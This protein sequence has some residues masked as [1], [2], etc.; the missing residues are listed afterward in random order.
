MAL[1]TCLVAERRVPHRPEGSEDRLSK[2]AP[3]VVPTTTSPVWGA[4]PLEGSPQ[5]EIQVRSQ[6]G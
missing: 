2:T 1:Q 6:L 3:E 5:A 4:H